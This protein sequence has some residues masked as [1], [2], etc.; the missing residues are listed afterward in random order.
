MCFHLFTA[1]VAKAVWVLMHNLLIANTE[2]LQQID[3]TTQMSYS[4]VICGVVAL[5]SACVNGLESNQM[6]N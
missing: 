1:V 2:H 5:F 3:K 6:L 4:R